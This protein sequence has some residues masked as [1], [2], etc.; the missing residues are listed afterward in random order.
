MNAA[1]LTLYRSA[2]PKTALTQLHPSDDGSNGY[3]ILA[4]NVGMLAGGNVYYRTG[5]LR[6]RAH[7]KIR[8]T[9]GSHQ[10]QENLLFS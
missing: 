10:H 4:H 6:V 9:N 1:P 7:S 2:T 3:L 8:A 5:A